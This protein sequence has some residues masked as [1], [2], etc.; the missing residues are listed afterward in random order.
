MIAPAIYRQFKSSLWSRGTCD[1]APSPARLGRISTWLGVLAAA[2]G[3][4][5]APPVLAAA[6]AGLAEA[7]FERLS[8]AGSGPAVSGA[9]RAGALPPGLPGYDRRAGQA[10]LVVA[11]VTPALT[12]ASGLRNLP[13]VLGI[14][15]TVTIN[16][17]TGT[18][19]QLTYSLVNAPAWI[20]AS[21]VASRVLELN[22]VSTSLLGRH[23]VTVR[24]VEGTV[25]IDAEFS[26]DVI[27]PLTLWHK[28]RPRG[29]RL[30]DRRYP[31]LYFTSDVCKTA[32]AGSISQ[33]SYDIGYKGIKARRV[34]F[35]GNSCTGANYISIGTAFG[36][37]WNKQSV[38]EHEFILPRIP[39][40]GIHPV[41]VQVAYRTRAYNSTGDN[42]IR[43]WYGEEFRID[44][45]YSEVA[46][47]IANLT[48]SQLPANYVVA[49]I[50]FANQI[51]NATW[52]IYRL[53]PPLV[54]TS[55][56][57]V[58]GKK[59]EGVVRITE[60]AAVGFSS[61]PTILNITIHSYSPDEAKPLK[62]SRAHLNLKI[63]GTNEPPEFS[64]VFADREVSSRSQMQFTFPAATDRESN[65]LSYAATLADEAESDLPSGISFDPPSREFTIVSGAAAGSWRIKVKAF[66]TANPD[67]HFDEQIFE[68]RI[69]N[70]IVVD[71]AGQGVL[72][73]DRRSATVSIKL[74]VQPS[75]NQNV[76][77]TLTSPDPA[78][79]TA[80]P[81]A[82][83]FTP[84]NWNRAQ[85]LVLAL[86]AGMRDKGVRVL[87]AQAAIFASSS[88]AVNYRSAAA[89]PLPVPLNITN[90]APSFASDQR[91]KTH[92]ENVGTQKYQPN[93]PIGTPVVATDSDNPTGLKYTMRHR[94]LVIDPD[95]GQILTGATVNLNHER[96]ASRLLTI[97]VHDNEPLHLRQSATVTVQLTLIDVVE[98]P[99]E[100]TQYNLVSPGQTGREITLVW[101]NKEY[102]DEFDVSDS[103]SVQVSY[104]T[105]G[106]PAV[107]QDDDGLD[108][109]PVTVSISDRIVSHVLTGLSAGTTY[110]V[111]L[112]WRT[113]DASMIRWSSQHV[114]ST[115]PNLNIA[116][117]F[118]ENMRLREWPENVGKATYEADVY[119]TSQGGVSFNSTSGPII[120]FDEDGDAVTYSLVGSSDLF[121]I[122]AGTGHL[123]TKREAHV[124]YERGDGYTVTV[125]A[126]DDFTPPASSRV[127]VQIS[128]ENVI[129]DTFVYSRGN[130]RIKGGSPTRL[131]LGWNN[132][133]Y[134]DQFYPVDRA[135]I[136]LEYAQYAQGGSTITVAMTPDTTEITLTGLRPETSYFLRLDWQ[137]H[138]SV[139]SI[140]IRNI[141]STLTVSRD[142]STSFQ[143]ATY[144]TAANTDPV[145]TASSLLANQD[146]N[147]GAA[148]TAR[149]TEVGRLVATD[150]ESIA[151]AVYSAR[152]GGNPDVLGV[153]A[154]TGAITL[155]ADTNLDKESKDLYTLNVQVED[156][157]GGSAT[158]QFV[159]TINNI[160][161]KPV[162]ARMLGNQRASQT[163]LVI[164]LPTASDAENAGITYAVSLEDGTALS[165]SATP[166]VSYDSTRHELTVVPNSAPVS[167][168]I[169][170]AAT[171]VGGSAQ[172]TEEVFIL[173][174]VADGINAD[175][176]GMGIFTR[177]NRVHNLPIELD[178]AP[179][180]Q[181]V[182]VIVASEDPAQLTARPARLVFGPSTWNTA[183]N[184]ILSLTQ[185]GTVTKGARSIDVSVRVHDASNSASNYRSVD[186]VAVAA[187]I[188]VSN[189]A[190][191]F[192]SPSPSRSIGENDG[193]GLTAAG[194]P[195]GLPIEA[196]DADDRPSELIYSLVGLSSV[197]GVDENS[198][199]I[200]L[201]T[202][203]NLDHETTPEYALTLKVE[204]NE[205]EAIRGRATVTV[206][207][208]VTGRAEAPMLVELV[209][210]TV[211]EG[212]D[213]IYQFA[214]ATDPDRGDSVTYTV[215][216]ANGANLPDGVTFSASQ[217]FVTIA[218]AA[219]LTAQT[220]TLRVRARDTG[221]LT[222]TRT[223]VLRVRDAGSAV[224]QPAPLPELARTNRRVVFN[225]RLDVQ[226][227]TQGVTIT[228]ES[229]V[230]SDVAVAP[231]TMQFDRS[232]WNV[233]Q[234]ATLSLSDSGARL[235]TDRTVDLS[236]GVHAQSASDVFYRGTRPQIIA[237]QVANENAVPDFGRAQVE[238]IINAARVEEV[239]A[240]E[241]VGTVAATDG[242]G[243]A[244]TY[245][246]VGGSDAGLF[247]IDENSG[248]ISFADTVA[249]VAAQLEPG[250][251]YNF[252]VE[253]ADDFGGMSRLEVQVR[254][255]VPAAE[256]VVALAVIDGAI[257][258][259]SADIIQTR[260]DASPGRRTQEPAAAEFAYEPAYMR[261]ASA[262]DHWHD[263]RGD[264]WHEAGETRQR[265]DWNDF[266]YGRGFDFA[267]DDPSSFGPHMRFWGLG[268]RSSLEGSPIEQEV[269]IPYSGDVNVLMLGVEAGSA[270]R[271]I[272]IAA[273]SSLAK[274][275][276]G[277]S[278]A[279]VRRE[280]K[281]LHPYANFR[282]N[283]SV[284][285]WMSGGFGF[286]DYARAETG[287]EEAVGD[288][289]YLFAAGGLSSAFVHER[290][291]I[292]IGLKILHV[293]SK[294]EAT[295]VLP[296]SK[297]RS[298]R[299]Q[300]DF[301]FGGWSYNIRPD[302]IF[303]PFVG[304]NI[305]YDNGNGPF[306][307]GQALDA[308]TGVRLNWKEVMDA[309]ISSRVQIQNKD[310]RERRIE[311]SLS[312]DYGSDRRG[313]MLSVTP[314]A[315]STADESF[316]S[317][318][319]VR[320]GYG[321]P[322]QLLGENGAATFSADF[323]YAADANVG[324]SYE[325]NFSGRRL[326]VDLAA[327]DDD[328][329]RLNLRIR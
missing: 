257:A 267:L 28:T 202:A 300:T 286:G 249:D 274:F 222:A 262:A 87:E 102:F 64:G 205:D 76:T 191:M 35:L 74:D 50:T 319:N 254:T 122:E 199:Q 315:S 307:Y 195:I 279:R 292:G 24:V 126:V 276:L 13:V 181:A 123:R 79:L 277:E 42:S 32:D 62:Q 57:P 60:A 94:V 174:I 285:F 329:Y 316:A 198:G 193:S 183:Q 252:V 160:D 246:I 22:P 133:G 140:V 263:W 77:V 12:F 281:S 40:E 175:A 101:N 197:F 5:S 27:R 291:E 104:E 303:K 44:Y 297:A 244:L 210:Q 270:S 152:A 309:H 238:F 260:L 224:V 70:G 81:A 68:L 6:S 124:N 168:R 328:A 91:I 26:V 11:Q 247:A 253:V 273:A 187:S 151:A 97:R 2:C 127:T 15:A 322:F 296:A 45:E 137:T 36:I 25:Q 234:N 56:T 46:L 266:L 147:E 14:E 272:G 229:K 293:Q 110:T 113:E 161:E 232:N 203:I 86:P 55:V 109:G 59:N 235:L 134:H 23:T 188:N 289:S 243:D 71:T 261:T 48:I 18:G 284:R 268:S 52:E 10:P 196:S 201:L 164:P 327:D 82:M 182:T 250:N 313:L 186:A 106:N 149:G 157:D 75:G 208:M 3:G 166:G 192:A 184:V 107:V 83:V 167:Y 290:M 251:S 325:L 88:S 148:T 265:A 194:S 154:D 95:S 119:I 269:R 283:D 236:I 43:E 298:W 304:M 169:K 237:L 41:T 51:D 171:E 271:K 65:A 256:E 221:G 312:Y 258:F 80:T 112:G 314:E 128:V 66:E 120:A 103:A 84:S 105:G 173:A 115:G 213:G 98:I 170:L 30:T 61:A 176:S 143:T 317:E 240:T 217:A 114:F 125:Q 178:S 38:D 7:G 159:L 144:T 275:T 89:V 117:V 241:I 280:L 135:T 131:T 233:A 218:F 310:A 67:S 141:D 58:A 223:F 158:G 31:V 318:V 145:L 111:S 20:D 78:K 72:T 320:A 129:E 255:P 99:S 211:I 216:Q 311:G 146:E 177:E 139:R 156:S 138:D 200:T 308:V 19:G 1:L 245:S 93:T 324:K 142:H 163:G 288:T 8:A 153:D 321:L 16:Q 190:P 4:L 121:R 185:A 326:D 85:Q 227:R 231:V 302:L 294:L 287:S 215:D 180:G 100:Y 136:A 165:P 162:F 242:N 172:T 219:R 259:A 204:D 179:M 264:G 73:S 212:V 39:G 69:V 295:E 33:L 92:N 47:T 130:F 63:S 96:L 34:S 207:I 189:A 228:L 248:R 54:S 301:E 21:N 155:V 230:A 282:I 239:V 90:A 132:D 299:M 226:P 108:S 323:S 118:P 220:V 209:D 225:V 53:D 49:T 9:E 278:N 29:F 150:S 306:E 17:A 206:A 305:R 37:M 116:P 214:A